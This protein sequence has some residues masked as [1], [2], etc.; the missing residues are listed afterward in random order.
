M[1][2]VFYTGQDPDEAH[3]KYDGIIRPP[4]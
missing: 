3:D 2:E 1:S 4:W